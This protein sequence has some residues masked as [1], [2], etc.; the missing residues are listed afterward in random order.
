[1]S[2]LKWEK[3]T[4]AFS[5]D[6]TNISIF[7]L[8]LLFWHVTVVFLFCGIPN[9]LS[10]AHIP[11]TSWTHF[12][13]LI[14][15]IFTMPFLIFKLLLRGKDKANHIP[16]ALRLEKESAS[17]KEYEIEADLKILTKKSA[18]YFSYLTTSFLKYLF[19]IF[20]AN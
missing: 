18:V 5:S 15:F 2:V 19:C 13:S 1:M 3:S 9:T 20:S 10:N 12:L 17:L 16:P 11:S 8:K 7:R 6:I 14:L 4:I